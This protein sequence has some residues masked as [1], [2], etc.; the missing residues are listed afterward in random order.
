[1]TAQHHPSLDVLLPRLKAFMDE[2]VRPQ[3]SRWDRESNE[4]GTTT[5][6]IVTEL[7]TLAREAGLWNL[8]LPDPAAGSGLTNLQY[9]PLAEEM[10]SV[11]WAS[12]VFNCSAPDTGNMELLWKYG[13]HEQ[14]ER[15]LTP[16]LAGEIRSAYLMT[17]PGVASSDA[18]NIETTV[19]RDGDSYI[20]NGRKWFA[21]GV[22]NPAC[23]IW[24]VMGRSST[25]GAR[26]TQHTQ[27][28]VE[29]DSPGITVVRP[30]PVLGVLEGSTGHAEVSFDNVRVPAANVILGEG[31]GFEIAQGRLGPG[32]IHHCMRTIGLAERALDAM[33]ERL[34]AR[35]TFG[36]TLADNEHWQQ[37]IAEARIDIDMAR[38]LTLDAAE[39]IDNHGIKGALA[40]V[41]MIKV[42][43][44]RMARRV[45]DQAI[46]A[47][48]A[49]GL[50]DDFRL[51]EMYRTARWVSIADGPDEVH[52]RTVARLELAAHRR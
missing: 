48:G 46:Q 13:S 51:P 31:R 35:A 23:A 12:E 47:F 52:A 16:L 37:K 45:I 18:T 34:L 36:R 30:L 3:E 40:K 7:K 2:H 28:L 32:R 5:P 39:T 27:I 33:C 6:A 50:T 24:I 9:A 19:T 42:A 25:D 29:P 8:F 43:V 4:C 11:H 14:K 49:A 21:T 44:P 38:L 10:G 1:M 41:A 22:L 20:V 17:E 15:W 26:H